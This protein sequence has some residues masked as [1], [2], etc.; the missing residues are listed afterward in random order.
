MFLSLVG[1]GKETFRKTVPERKSRSESFKKIKC[2]LITKNHNK[3]PQH[4]PRS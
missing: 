2:S 3:K 1:G 4:I